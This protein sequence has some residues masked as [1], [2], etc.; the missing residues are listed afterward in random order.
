MY[1][2][3]RAKLGLISIL[4][5]LELLLVVGVDDPRIDEECE[6]DREEAG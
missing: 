1:P 2:G 3:T 4:V 6:N 5:Y